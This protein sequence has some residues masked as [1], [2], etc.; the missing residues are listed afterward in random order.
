MNQ[1]GRNKRQRLTEGEQK[2]GQSDVDVRLSGGLRGLLGGRRYVKAEDLT[3][4]ILLEYAKRQGAVVVTE[5]NL[6]SVIIQTM[7]GTELEVK[8]EESQNTVKWLKLAIQDEQGIS[9]F[10][11]QLFLVSKGGDNNAACASGGA[12]AKQEP[13]KDDALMTDLGIVALCVDFSAAL[14]EW[15][16]SHTTTEVAAVCFMVRFCY[17]RDRGPGR[18]N[19]LVTVPLM[20]SYVFH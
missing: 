4:E 3:R 12:G 2:D 16:C 9:T 14:N 13:L 10:T 18:Q 7:G 15:D 19:E 6:L 8:L 17:K 20:C 5:V 1:I 11:Q